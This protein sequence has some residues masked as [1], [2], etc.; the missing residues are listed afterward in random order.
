MIN[1]GKYN[2]KIK[3]YKVNNGVDKD[4]FK[5]ENKE[6][7]LTTFANVKT[8]RGFTLIANNSDFEKAFT[9]FT[10]RFPKTA[11]TRDM[12]IEFHGKIYSIEYLNNIDEAGIELEIQAKDVTH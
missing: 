10:I 12:L 6:I 9:N 4:G 8:T 1:A 3:I 7:I 5:T 2:H 11:I